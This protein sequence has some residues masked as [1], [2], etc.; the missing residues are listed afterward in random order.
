MDKSRILKIITEAEAKLVTLDEALDSG[1]SEEANW[2]FVVLAGVIQDLQR[3]AEE[4]PIPIEIDKQ[5]L[6][7]T[8]Q[9]AWNAVE[10][11]RVSIQECE[12][13]LLRLNAVLLSLALQDMRKII[14][15]TPQ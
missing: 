8:F 11:G 6:S 4:E 3:L 14:N 13:R 9:S 7:M 12:Y 1:N 5:K 2:I 10:E 15:T